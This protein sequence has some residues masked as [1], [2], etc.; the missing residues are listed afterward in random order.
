MI[1][2]TSHP[3]WIT[4]ITI[5]LRRLPEDSKEAEKLKALTSKYVLRGE[6]LYEHGYSTPILRCL[7]SLVSTKVLLSHENQQRL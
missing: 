6:V 4:P 2:N 3:T 5:F 1:E 7:N